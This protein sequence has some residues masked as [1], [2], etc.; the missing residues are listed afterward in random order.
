M[1]NSG[2]PIQFNNGQVLDGDANQNAKVNLPLLP[3]QAGNALMIIDNNPQGVKNLGYPLVSRDRKLQVGV[4]T[5]LFDYSFASTVQNTNLW[6][7]AST[8]QVMAQSG[9]ALQVNSGASGV[10]TTGTSLTTWRQFRVDGTAS[11]VFDFY[12]TLT[13]AI[14]ASQNFFFGAYHP[15]A[16]PQNQ[17]TDGVFFRITS[18]GL[19]GGY[20][21]NNGS[22]QTVLLAGPASEIMLSFNTIRQYR[23]VVDQTR[24]LFWVEDINGDLI[25]LGSIVTPVAQGSAFSATQVPLCI[26]SANTGA[27]GATPAQMRFTQCTAVLRDNNNV[28][29]SRDA[30][31]LKGNTGAKNTEG[32]AIGNTALLVNAI[33]TQPAAPAALAN[34]TVA[35]QFLGLGGYFRITPTLALN[36]DGILCS[37]QSPAAAIPAVFPR[38]LRIYG[39]RVQGV[40]Q[41]TAL[42]GGPGIVRVGVAHNHT[43]ISLAATDTASFV[44]GT[45]KQAIRRLIGIES[46][47]VNAPIGTLGPLTTYECN[48]VI[49][50][51]EFFQ[52]FLKNEGVIFTAGEIGY[53]VDIQS[54]WVDA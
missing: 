38:P 47:P 30:S 6:R 5:P 27:V 39:V 49:N 36:T 46:W 7:F 13:S 48:I 25:R 33:G 17:P 29:D 16:L 14:Q 10:A 51:G 9:N 28:I 15:P 3:A 42:T 20:V 24:L 44:N 40:V 37:F 18:A 45:V 19:E 12:G 52:V 35:A 54:E 1:P 21:F 53:Q 8:T 32:V 22:V 26:Q 23:I 43:V 34:A 31:Q 4:D 41:G 2:M 11:T 50:P